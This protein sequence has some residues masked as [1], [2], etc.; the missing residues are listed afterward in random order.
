MSV[1]NKERVV[2]FLEVITNRQTSLAASDDNGLNPR[3]ISTHMLHLTKRPGWALWVE[4][5]TLKT[6][7]HRAD[8]PFCAESQDG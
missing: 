7:L 3:Y 1:E 8:Y 2:L 5:K 6:P 4:N